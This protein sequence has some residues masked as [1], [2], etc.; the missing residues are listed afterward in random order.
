MIIAVDCDNTIFV[1]VGHPTIGPPVPF[2]IEYLQEL[3]KEGA[4]LI[5]WTLRSGAAL[6]S[7]VDSL[8]EFGVE[9]WDYNENPEQR[10][11]NQSKKVYAHLYID[12][13]G[14]GIPLMP[15]NGEQVVDWSK[16]GPMAM[17]KLRI[18]NMVHQ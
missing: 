12:D 11:W 7:A 14:L 17:K 4:K 9:F 1:D 15:F 13:K 18:Y 8:Q 16:A 10:G 2:A 5:L 3:R 6:L